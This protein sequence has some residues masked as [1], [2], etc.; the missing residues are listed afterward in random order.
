M[1]TITDLYKVE[2]VPSKTRVNRLNSDS[3]TITI[4]LRDYSDN[5]VKASKSVTVAASTGK[6]N[7]STSATV[8]TST[9]T[10]AVTVTYTPNM[11][12]H[13][14]DTVTVKIGNVVHE[15]L[16][17]EIYE[18]T[19]WNNITYTSAYQNYHPTYSPVRYRCYNGLVEIKGIFE[20]KNNNVTSN[21]TE[22]QFGSVPSAYAPQYTSYAICQGSNTQK[23]LINVATDGKLYWTRNANTDYVNLKNPVSSTSNHGHWLNCYIVYRRK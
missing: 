9:S 3:C 6:I 14:F 22:V 7:N 1:V 20:N 17:F 10:G 2:V 4:T 21:T 13:G 16:L 19:G 12:S 15:T 11:T 5:L 23:V 8:S 18:D